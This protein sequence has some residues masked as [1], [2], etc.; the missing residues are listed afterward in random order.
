MNRISKE[1]HQ[2]R[3]FLMQWYKLSNITILENIHVTKI[4]LRVLEINCNDPL[5]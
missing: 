1:V 4:M 3:K 5:K 2:F